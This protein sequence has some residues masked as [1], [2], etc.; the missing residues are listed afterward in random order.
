MEILQVVLLAFLIEAVWE[1]L[2]MVWQENKISID[3]VGALV[4]GLG[5]AIFYRVDL[6]HLAGIAVSFSYFGA[7]LSGILISRGGNYIH[8]LVSRLNNRKIT[9]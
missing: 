7:V 3:R 8:D 9:E 5:V 4:I 1:T 2:K 6:I